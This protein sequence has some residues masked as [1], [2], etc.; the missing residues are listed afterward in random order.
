M[1]TV[2]ESGAGCWPNS[3]PWAL[4]STLSFETCVADG[5]PPKEPAFPYCCIFLRVGRW[6]PAQA[7][8]LVKWQQQESSVVHLDIGASP[9]LGSLCPFSLNSS[10]LVSLEHGLHFLHHMCF[11]IPPRNITNPNNS[12][13]KKAEHMHW[14]RNQSAWLIHYI[15]ILIDLLYYNILLYWYTILTVE[16]KNLI[17]P[18]KYI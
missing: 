6:N 9:P 2:I 1:W 15:V 11:L 3:W 14:S 16:I 12:E 17:Y 4:N 7:S 10:E 13:D 18:E 5:T 8:C